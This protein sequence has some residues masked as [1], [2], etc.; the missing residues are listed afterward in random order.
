MPPSFDPV[1]LIG[2]SQ[3]AALAGIFVRIGRVGERS[4][5]NQ[6]WVERMRDAITDLNDRVAALEAND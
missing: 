5:T 2:L 4:E 1:L 3:L 6:A